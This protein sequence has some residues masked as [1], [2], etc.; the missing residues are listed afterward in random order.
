MRDSMKT[1]LV[2]LLAALLPC[3]AGAAGL[4]RLNVLS[5]LGQP[6]IAEIE[7][8]S[9][10]REEL[11]S[12]NARLAHPDAYRLANLQYNPALTGTRLT[13]ER[14]AGGQHYIKLV[15]TRPVSEPFIDLL[16]ELTWASGRLSREYTALLD[17]PG[18]TPAAP[19]P[20]ISAVPESRPAPEPQ[21]ATAPEPVAS[22]PVT[23]APA[24]VAP[25]AGGKEY[26]P[27]ERGETLG[28]IAQSVMPEGVTL[29]QMLVALY[30]SNPDAF[31]RKNLNLVRA[32]KILRVPDREEVAAIGSGEAVK[33]YRAHV[34]D[35]NSYRQKVAEAAGTVPVEGRTA[36]SGKI[37]TKVEDKIAGA[38]KD[39][40]KL[41]KGEAPGAGKGKPGSPADRVRMLEE[42]AVAREKALNEAN[43][44]IAQL[45]KTLQDM[46]KLVELKSPG[47]AAAQQKA[48]QA[49]TAKPDTMAAAKPEPAKPE[50][51]KPQET[52]SAIAKPE[53]KSETMAAPAPKK[54]VP[55]SKPKAKPAAKAKEPELVDQIMGAATDPLY[56]GIG[57]G[58]L[59]LGGLAFFL[60]RRRRSRADADEPPGASR[61][62]TAAATAAGAAA[63]TADA[64]AAPE[65][66]A[67][68]AEDVDPLAEA[69]VYIAYGRDGQAE[70]ILKDA[71][72][73]NPKREDAQ[74]KLLEIY[75]ARKDKAA[76]AK[77]A[78]DLN[79][80]TGGSGDNWIKAAAMG[81]ALDSSNPLYAAGKDAVVAT[82]DTA[83]ADVDLDLGMGEAGTSTDITLDAGTAATG[84]DGAILDLGAGEKAEAQPQ[85]GGMPDFALEVP[86][87]EG[88]QSNPAPEPAAPAQDAGGMLDFQIELPKAA[89]E[90]ATTAT[91]PS[92]TASGADAGLDFKL[93]GLN[94][95][96]DDEPKTA[97]AAGGEKDGH[98]YD[99]QTKFDLAKAY[100]EMGDKD[101]AKEILQEVIKEGDTEQKSQAKTLLDSLG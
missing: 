57:G 61:L 78:G 51:V 29:E 14:R 67:A 18:I 87:A 52:P 10:T 71:L 9:A 12:L 99:V 72:S 17:P 100:Q 97:A 32:G 11:G 26:G 42:E 77:Q 93:D 60:A 21:P 31:I 101:G 3:V 83:V 40:V 37:T 75:S 44:R 55:A 79:K 15:S 56:L 91:P 98:W 23:P 94:L 13:I 38:P 82:A 4:G 69:E 36:V 27:I 25:M 6:L 22:R 74:L 7:L 30:R 65:P 86:A 43:E 88:A 89:E 92:A 1:W 20:V 34:T 47:M 85:P 28:K 54:D 39:V 64:T 19:A 73:K 24:P 53:E 76:F 49:A 59:V 2:A 63:I 84:T 46:K 50:P 45:E 66:A 48:Q 16:I 96:L 62:G 95:N 58:V 70:E 33:E 8:V 5:S 81:Y 35:W 41:S 90:P 80:L 68:G